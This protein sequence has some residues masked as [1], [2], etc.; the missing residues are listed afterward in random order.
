[1]P[2]MQWMK[3]R[4]TSW[5]VKPR[6]GAPVVGRGKMQGCVTL[7]VTEAELVSGCD[8]TQDMLYV[9]RL[10]ESIGLKVKK[11]MVLWMDNK[12]AVDLANSWTIAGRTRHVATKVTF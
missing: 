2:S 7:S 10:L 9:M 3:S 4:G 1:M 12:G 11:P 8:C 5:A 6:Y